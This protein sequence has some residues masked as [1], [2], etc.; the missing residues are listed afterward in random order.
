MSQIIK[1]AFVGTSCIG[2]TTLLNQCQKLSGNII[3]IDE[4]DREWF[5]A[6]PDVTDR[7]GIDAQGAILQFAIDHEVQA[8]MRA[9]SMHADE[10]VIIFCDRSLLDPSAYL[11]GLGNADDAET[12]FTIAAPFIASYD[13]IFLLD[14]DDVPY[15]MDEIRTEDEATRQKFHQGFIDFFALHNIAYELLSGT[16]GIRLQ[17]VSDFIRQKTANL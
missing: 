11:Y 5:T 15:Q 2:K 13:K 1:V 4:P 12:L 8:D 17:R 16:A 9:Q 10:P 7:F 6:H 14:P 3:T